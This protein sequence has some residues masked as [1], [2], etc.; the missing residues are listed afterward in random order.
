M[1]TALIYC[2]RCRKVRQHNIGEPVQALKFQ[3]K[4][5]CTKCGYIRYRAD[6]PKQKKSDTEVEIRA[7]NIGRLRESMRGKLERGTGREYASH[8]GTLVNFNELHRV[9]AERLRKQKGW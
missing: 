7:K 8:V 1:S 4:I 3:Y 2:T 6:L 9:I 5:T